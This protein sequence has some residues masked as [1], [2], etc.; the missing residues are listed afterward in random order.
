M[1]TNSES[2]PLK[3]VVVLD[4]G[5]IKFID[6]SYLHFEDFKK[7]QKII[8]NDLESEQRAK[9]FD[10]EYDCLKDNQNFET[11]IFHRLSLKELVKKTKTYCI[12]DVYEVLEVLNNLTIPQAKEVFQN[13]QA[14]MFF[15]I[16]ISFM[17]DLKDFKI[18]FVKTFD[19]YFIP[20]HDF[21]MC[22]FFED[23]ISSKVLFDM[24]MNSANQYYQSLVNAN[25]EEDVAKLCLPLSKYA[26]IQ[27]EAQIDSWFLFIKKY[28]SNKKSPIRSYA[29]ALYDILYDLTPI[30]T[31]LFGVSKLRNQL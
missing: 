4:R 18:M 31:E 3:E 2:Q 6:A 11:N 14:R 1:Q 19:E 28:I 15:K 13:L 30:S 9:I 7:F 12:F 16:P 22:R 29:I 21:K 24:A 23:N 26:L 8:K 27:I 17:E 20:N 10:Y 5:Y 25:I